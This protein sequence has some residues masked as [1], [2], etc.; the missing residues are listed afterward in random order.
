M[1]LFGN[2]VNSVYSLDYR[3]PGKFDTKSRELGVLLLTSKNISVDDGGVFERALFPDR[4][5][6]AKLLVNGKELKVTGFHSITGCDHKKA[7]SINFL[8]FAEAV[9]DFRPDIVTIDANE[10]SMD[11]Y[12]IDKMQFFDKN[13]NGAKV[14]FNE[15]SE[16]GLKDLYSIDFNPKDYVD[17]Q[18]LAVS[19]MIKRKGPC[20]YDFIFGNTDRLDI[21]KVDYDYEGAVR[22]TADHAMIRAYVSLKGENSILL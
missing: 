13:G 5:I 20:R 11:H 16:I 17:G 14:F 22:A 15:L 21:E 4:T 19:H 3:A 1:E 7:K 8:S 12:Q 6:W 10:P 18:P 9:D 2:V